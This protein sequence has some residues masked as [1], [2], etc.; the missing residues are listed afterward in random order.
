MNAK[1]TARQRAELIMKVRAGQLSVKAAAAQLGVSRKTYYEWEAKG[2]SA[3]LR[4]L[5]DQEA[6]RPVETASPEIRAMQEKIAAL[7]QKL[8]VA[9]QTAEIRAVL[10]AMENAA[11][12]KKRPGSKK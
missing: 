3:M 9:S 1:E 10:L 6:G 8:A 7:E 11:A 5:E 2:L 4:H 12:K